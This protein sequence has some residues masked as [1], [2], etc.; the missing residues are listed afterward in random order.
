MQQGGDLCTACGIIERGAGGM[1]KLICENPFNLSHLR[2][3]YIW[4]A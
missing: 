1:E 2:S 4:T 3:I